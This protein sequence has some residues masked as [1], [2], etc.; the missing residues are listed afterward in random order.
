MWIFSEFQEA[1]VCEFVSCGTSVSYFLCTHVS[2]KCAVK[3][4]L[5][6]VLY[7]CYRVL[8]TEL[9]ERDRM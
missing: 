7:D 9:R 8:I 5:H 6:G 2:K 4:N 3:M 1:S